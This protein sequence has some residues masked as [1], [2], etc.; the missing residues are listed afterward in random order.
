MPRFYLT[1]AIDYA[2]GDP[3]LGHALEKIGAD[4][5]C[6]FRRQLG[7]DVWF[8][9]GMDEHGQKVAQ[10]AEAAG[11]A[12]QA[13]VDRVAERFQAMWATLD[14]RYDQF[15]RTS[16]AAHHAAVRDLLERIFTHSPDDFYERS[17]TGL[18]CVGCESFKQPA[19]ITDGKCA[20]HLTRTLEEI[21]ERN[22]FFRLSAYS[23][24]L[25]QHL[26]A[27]PE[28]L[29][30]ASRRNE[31]LAL[32]DQ[33]LED[34]SASRAR[35]AWGVPFPRPLSDGETQTTYV[36]FDALPNYW[37]AQFFPDS[38]AS[39]PA[40]VHVIGKDIT[41]FHTVIWPAMLMAAGLPLPERVWAHGFISLGGERFSKSAG[42]KLELAEAA[43]RFGS[44]AFRYYLL[45]DIPFDGD[46]AFSWE[47]F[48][49][50][51]TSELANGLGNLASRTTAM[52]EKYCDGVVPSGPRGD[53]DAADLADL[54][55]ARAAV[56]G[57]RGFLLH[58]AVAAVQ[59]TVARAN[60]YIQDTKPWALAKDPAQR[61]QLDTVLSSL[62]RQLA[63]QAVYLAPVMPNKAE[64]LWRA[65]GG[66]GTAA[67]TLLDTADALDCAGWKVSKG[68]G[69]FP[70]P[71]PPA[72]TA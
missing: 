50:V 60:Q 59:R 40:Q 7:D 13:F 31:I 16:H 37:T 1:T 21:T 33:G 9:T 19:D 65:L 38:K 30:P 8:L 64:A 32:L 56:A 35:F 18:Y 34:I 51:Y 57:P 42:V 41:R 43:S 4:A 72:V 22:W 25:K 61:A 58:E 45:R 63:R 49:A 52:I 54:A 14:V 36:W 62:A 29:E 71:E 27:H 70:R 6:R 66:P 69:L 12:P 23:T 53:V 47:R 46:G 68:E 5:I 26:T 39:W 2:N 55:E 11:L 24:R 48:E 3:H 20:L 17:Y 28:F 10:T 44:D 15:M 67:A